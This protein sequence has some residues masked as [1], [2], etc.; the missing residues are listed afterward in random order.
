MLLSPK[1]TQINL[2][3]RTPKPPHTL[4]P[5][6]QISSLNVTPNATAHTFPSPRRCDNKLSKVVVESLSCTTIGRAG[7]LRL[8]Y[9]IPPRPSK[10][11]TAH[12]HTN[13]SGD[14]PTYIAK[15]SSQNTFNLIKPSN[16]RSPNWHYL[17]CPQV[18]IPYPLS[19]H[20]NHP[21]TRAVRLPRPMSAW[22]RV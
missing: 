5:Q 12:H 15:P 9:Q 17:P 14:P 11:R 8:A 6:C 20:F 2:I 3:L 1:P 22:T 13:V 7:S 19:T 16:P 4:N 21:P 18:Y 10:T